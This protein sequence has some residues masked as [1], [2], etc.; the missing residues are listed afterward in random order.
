MTRRRAPDMEAA[1]ERVHRIMRWGYVVYEFSPYHVRVFDR[2]GKTVADYWPTSGRWRY[3]RS[4]DGTKEGL[5]L[6]ALKKYLNEYHPI[7]EDA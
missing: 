2:D 7:K 1:A 5:G 4:F 6:P 3:P